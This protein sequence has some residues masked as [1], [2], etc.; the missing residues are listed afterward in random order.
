[1]FTMLKKQIFVTMAI[2]IGLG[3][4]VWIL[5]TDATGGNVRSSDKIA[6]PFKIRFNFL[7]QPETGQEIG[8]RLAVVMDINAPDTEIRIYLPEG[9][10]HVSGPLSWTGPLLKGESQRLDFVIRI[11]EEINA[12]IRSH[13]HCRLLNGTS[14][15]KVKSLDINL[16]SETRGKP[17]VSPLLNSEGEWIIEKQGITR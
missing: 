14:F 3:F 11:P 16:G 17:Q 9:V 13:V 15:S 8:V 6:P 1:M 7:N 10:E 12:T 4:F 5:Q 2:L